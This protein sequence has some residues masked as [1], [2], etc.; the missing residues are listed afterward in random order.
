VKDNNQKN[1]RIL[2]IDDNEAIHKDFRE[3]LSVKGAGAAALNE[4][5]AAILGTGPEVTQL[6]S[7]EID[8]AFQG[9]EG[10]KKVQE[11][12]GEGRPY[13]MAFV[14]IRMPPGWDGIETIR[15]IWDEYPQLQVV[16]CTAYSDYQWQD[17]ID[18]LGQTDQL[19]IL[20][21]P[22]DNV[23]VRQ[24][25]CALTEKWTLARQ[26]QLKQE[27]LEV[28]VKERTVELTAANEELLRIQKAVES[29]SDAIGMSDPKGYHFYQNRA[30]TELFGCE[31][32]ELQTEEGPSIV[33][34]NKDVARDVFATIQAGKSWSG[35][36]EMIVKDGRT[37]S[38]L[39]RADAVKDK[40]GE[41]VG[42]I[43]IHTDITE[44]KQAE[45]A[46]RRSEHFLEQVLNA[47]QDGISV[48]DPELNIV[49]VND[50][51]RVLYNHMLPLEGKKCYEAYHGRSEPC[52]V[53]PTR[54]AFETSQI[55]MEE[56]PLEQSEGVTGTLELFAFP[57]LDDSGRA[58]GVVEYVRD[59]SDRKRA[60]LELR[61]QDRLKSEFVINV[62]HELRTPLTIFKNI[63]SNALAGVMGKLNDKQRENLEIADKEIDRLARIIREFLDI[64]KIESGKVELLPECVSIQSI[65]TDTLKLLQSLAD[66]KSVEL[67]SLM[68]DGAELFVNADR[69]RITQVLTNL[70]DNAIKFVPDCG[71]RVT[72][73]VRDLDGEI[74]VGV[75]DN[76]TGI[77][78]DDINRVFNRFVQVERHIGPGSHGTGLG[79]AICKE[80]VELHGGRI[81]VENLPAG[82]ANFCFV[83]PKHSVEPPLE[84]IGAGERSAAGNPEK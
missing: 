48:L 30:F 32:E 15:R 71:G 54:R 60:E 84:P 68:P 22:F 76:G 27:D 34:V 74:G 82:G 44:R 16:I 4:A 57:V 58:T 10:L 26:T 51:M 17:I 21:K 29:S 50:A 8:S 59:I 55:A 2:V 78:G 3:I 64:A 41:I 37:I 11:A 63:V 33:Y 52:E 56:V 24:L 53:C 69:D 9:Q 72:V 45:Q 77:E 62:S 79:L 7:F 13:A 61:E 36:I 5:K 47:I 75:E 49:R 20:K 66:G 43:G 38:V 18:K 42:L 65:V 80:L 6:E 81:W 67:K 19:L 73:R 1:R 12:L 70:V 35:E 46:I 83:L 23:E 31:L 39:L 25:A 14:D 28:A 40:S